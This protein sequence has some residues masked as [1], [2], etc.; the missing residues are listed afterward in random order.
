MIFKFSMAA[1]T[2]INPDV[3]VTT[4]SDSVLVLVNTGDPLYNK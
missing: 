3:L 2:A 4:P 1:V